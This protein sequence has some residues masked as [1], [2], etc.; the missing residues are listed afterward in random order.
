MIQCYSADFSTLLHECTMLDLLNEYGAASLET[1]LRSTNNLL[2]S[3]N[4]IP[5]VY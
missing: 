5:S 2:R 4:S 1:P 3:T